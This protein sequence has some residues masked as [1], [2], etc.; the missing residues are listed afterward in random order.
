MRAYIQHKGGGPT[1]GNTF[2]AT[3]GFRLLGVETVPFEA[4]ELD[5][6]PLD[7]ETLVCGYVGIVH[8]ALE[9]LG[10]AL[11]ALHPAPPAVAA[12]YGRSIRATTLGEVRTL[13]QPIFVKPLSQHKAFTGHVRRGDLDDLNRTAHLDDDFDVLVSDVVD[14]VSEWRC[15]ILRGRCVGAKPYAGDV[16]ATSPDWRVLDGA[17]DALGDALPAGCSID[18]GVTREG[19][20][21]VVEMNDGYAL[22]CY[23]LAAVPYAQLLEARWLEIVSRADRSPLRATLR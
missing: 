14:F 2:N 21:L 5:A 15:F 1:N 9:R 20:T 18:L 7:R 13:D 12:F 4:A 19:A 6:L 11:P 16:R 23:G 17:L 8:R 3:E 22:G 10:V